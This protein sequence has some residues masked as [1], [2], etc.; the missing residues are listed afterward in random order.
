VLP[1]AYP[2]KR[3][4]GHLEIS[5]VEPYSFARKSTQAHEKGKAARRDRKVLAELALAPSRLARV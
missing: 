5:D 4:N 1:L 3:Q 2:W